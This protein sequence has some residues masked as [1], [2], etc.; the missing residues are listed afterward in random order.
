[1]L[2]TFREMNGYA[3]N[4][5]DGELGSVY[6]L[7]FDDETWNVRYVV[8]ETGSWLQSRRVLISPLAVL[9]TDRRGRRV[10]VELTREQVAASPPIES[11]I[12]VS[13]QKELQYRNY[14]AWPAYWIGAYYSP[15]N[16]TAAPP[17]F[18]PDPG[19][20]AA[21]SRGEPMTFNEEAGDPHLRSLRAIGNYHVVT[22]DG[23][24]GRIA[25]FVIEDWRVRDFVVET[26]GWLHHR[27]LLLPPYW[28]G[29]VSWEMA[30]VV[31]NIGSERAFALS[32]YHGLGD[33]ARNAWDDTDEA[34]AAMM[35]PMALS[36]TGQEAELLARL[37]EHD[38]CELRMEVGRTDDY[39]L[40]QAL[41]RDEAILKKLMERVGGA[42]A[43][44]RA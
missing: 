14:F 39:G 23:P 35:P 26:G 17:V 28:V 24:V 9:G 4:A 2:T 37:L 19:I 27:D 25:D 21:T 31:L 22:T 1:M 33:L 41:K 20:K 36:L 29:R 8:V 34:R 5:R 12:P 6:D 18:A 40:R 7:F 3:I 30:S 38:L 15:V 43:G 10:D 16:G 44:A 11:D 13:R 32:E 42:P